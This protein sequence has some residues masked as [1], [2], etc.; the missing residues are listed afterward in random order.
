MMKERQQMWNKKMSPLN[1]DQNN[2]RLWHLVKTLNKGT[3]SSYSA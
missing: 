2:G 1:L 3:T